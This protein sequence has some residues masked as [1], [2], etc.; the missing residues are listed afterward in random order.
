MGKRPLRCRAGFYPP[1]FFSPGPADPIPPY[2]GGGGRRGNTTQR[3]DGVVQGSRAIIAPGELW[4]ILS[5][6]PL[7]L[8]YGGV[9]HEDLNFV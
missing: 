9:P 7:S 6:I 2:D 4:L 8:T 5:S 1:A 3:H